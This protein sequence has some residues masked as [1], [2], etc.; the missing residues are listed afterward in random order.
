M[1]FAQEYKRH[2]GFLMIDSLIG[3]ILSFGLMFG[4]KLYIE[5]HL[6]DDV[7]LEEAVSDNLNESMDH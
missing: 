5:K 6:N 2:L 7:P 3:M 1:K 4:A